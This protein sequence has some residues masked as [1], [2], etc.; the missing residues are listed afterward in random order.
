MRIELPKELQNGARFAALAP[1]LPLNNALHFK[2]IATD[3]REV[4]PGDLFV[5]IRGKCHNGIVFA[6]EAAKNGAVAMLC[7]EQGD[8]GEL[9][10]ASF[11]VPSVNEALLTAAAAW[12]KQLSGQVI[13]VSGSTG[14][15]TVKEVIA[16][17]LGTKG[18]VAKSQ[19]NFNSQI[20]VPL[21]LLAMHSVDY[22]VL[23]VGVSRVGEMAPL[24][25]AV[26]PHV[27][28]LTNIGT[29]HIG[30]FGS[31]E[32][33]FAE[34]LSILSGLL[35]GVHL[36]LP[37]G[38]ANGRF[39]SKE[40]LTF[41][42][43]R[44]ADFHITG[45]RHTRE[46]SAA[47]IY[48]RGRV[49][50]DISWHIPGSVGLSTVA[51]GA[52]VGLYFGLDEEEIRN[53]MKA[54]S[55]ASPRMKRRLMAGRH[56]I[57]DTYNASPEAVIAALEALCYVGEGAP[58]AAVLGDICEL[59][60]YAKRLHREV[61]AAAAGAQLSHLFSYGAYAADLAEGALA[62][63]MA[64]SRV[65]CFAF[66]EEAGLAAAVMAAMPKGAYILCKASRAVGLERVIAQ[67]ERMP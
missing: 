39:Q 15:T 8:T 36:L 14:K 1:F 32:A 61:G 64:P 53:A 17:V 19:G 28:V 44:G 21:S 35:K 23:E 22:H 16:T 49:A 3:S 33:I 10:L 37:H 55:F 63:G 9:P 56:V 48:Y 41:G 52:A 7:E 6:A 66:G 58:R 25:K 26:A 27:A 12:R 46:G 30:S 38:L 50:T 18:R 62:T 31:K 59:G 42:E 67:F 40:M 4:Q 45:V 60:K 47:D 20:G 29:A 34:K 43:A 13:A 11:A 5:A 51:I 24:A 2:G 65:H 57:D 54:A